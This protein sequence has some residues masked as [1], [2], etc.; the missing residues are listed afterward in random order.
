MLELETAPSIEQAAAPRT[1][2]VRLFGMEIDRVTLPEAVHRVLDWATAHEGGCRYVV[3][4]NLDHAVMFQENASLRAAYADAALILADGWP[5]VTASR[6]LGKPLPER[7]AGSDLTPALFSA[8]CQA[9]RPLRVFL[10][11][12]APG[13]AERAAQVIEKRWPAVHVCG[14]C[15]PPLGFEREPATSKRILEQVAAARPDLLVVGLGAPK[16]ELWLHAHRNELE[17]PV[18]LGV[19]ATIDFLAGERRRAPRWMQRIHLEWLHRLANEPRRLASRYWR[20]ATVF[21]KLLYRD[22][23]EAKRGRVAEV[24][25]SEPPAFQR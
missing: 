25:Q 2:R 16:Q 3:T 10:L 1:E 18:A 11:G 5:L 9:R 22:W 12:A 8:A 17:V 21:P 19:G 14:H 20:D 7:V 23:C 24:E 15:S 6:W 4:P 13:V